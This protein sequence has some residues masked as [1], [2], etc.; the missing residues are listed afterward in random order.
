MKGLEGHRWLK[1]AIVL[2]SL[3]LM[4]YKTHVKQFFRDFQWCHKRLVWAFSD[5]VVDMITPSCPRS[6]DSSMKP[7]YSFSGPRGTFASVSS[8]MI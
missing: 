1:I 8:V 4:L 2:N 7:T 3:L 5:S 6:I